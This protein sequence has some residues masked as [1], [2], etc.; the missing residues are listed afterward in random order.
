MLFRSRHESHPEQTEDS[1]G[2]KVDWT[3]AST[4][5]TVA[6]RNPGPDA[7]VQT[8]PTHPDAIPSLFKVRVLI[9]NGFCYVFSL[10]HVFV[11]RGA[12][13]SLIT[14]LLN[15]HCVLCFRSCCCAHVRT[16]PPSRECYL[17]PMYFRSAF[18]P[19]TVTYFQT[20]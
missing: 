6:F 3:N 13:H 17:Q 19:V 14:L 20:P 9:L 5:H 10:A 2:H 1:E 7:F 15:H 11:I 8:F 18:R 16:R 12:R 4:G